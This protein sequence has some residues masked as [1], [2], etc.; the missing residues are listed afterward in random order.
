MHFDAWREL[1][2]EFL[3]SLR[4]LTADVDD[5]EKRVEDAGGRSLD[6]FTTAKEAELGEAIP[7]YDVIRSFGYMLDG[8][9]ANQFDKVPG[10]DLSRVLVMVHNDRLF[11]LNFIPDDP[12]AGDA[13]DEMQALYDV[14]IESF[15]FLRSS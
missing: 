1:F 8:V 3:A 2:D 14:V 9:P 10:Q 7:G 4:Q 11:T 15:S 12:G 5:L 6:E 13:Y